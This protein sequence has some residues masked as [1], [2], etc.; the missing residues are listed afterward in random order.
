MYN[1]ETSKS[2][3]IYITSYKYDRSHRKC[4][5]EPNR[6]KGRNARVRSTWKIGVSGGL[7][8]HKE[9]AYICLKWMSGYSYSQRTERILYAAL[10]NPFDVA[11]AHWSSC[12]YPLQGRYIVATW[13]SEVA[14]RQVRSIFSANF[15]WGGSNNKVRLCDRVS[16][17]PEWSFKICYLPAY[18]EWALDHCDLD[19]NTSSRLVMYYSSFEKPYMKKRSSS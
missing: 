16:S 5:G 1:P 13:I 8:N 9:P 18:H 12:M 10:A 11:I 15:D 2:L 17:A 4:L 14:L 7:L 6:P 19:L 3:L